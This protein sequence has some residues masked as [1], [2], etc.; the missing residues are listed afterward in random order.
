MG[1]NEI[2]KRDNWFGPPFRYTT[3]QGL[4]PPPPLSSNTL[5]VKFSWC[6][7]PY[8]MWKSLSGPGE[9]KHVSSFHL[10][11]AQCTPPSP[12]LHKVA[13]MIDPG[14][15]SCLHKGKEAQNTS[16]L[17]QMTWSEEEPPRNGV[18]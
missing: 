14:S 5:L 7:P 15:H 2:Y 13:S 6:S 12:T 17:E 4:D 16:T 18:K 8:P 3:F 10:P 1:E 9:G 11:S